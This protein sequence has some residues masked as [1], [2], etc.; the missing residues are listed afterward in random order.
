MRASAATALACAL[1]GAGCGP[2]VDCEALC[3]RLLACRVTLDAPDDPEGAKIEAGERTEDESCALGCA[4]SGV[5]TVERARCVD[6]VEIR[7]PGVCQD[8]ML[9]CLEQR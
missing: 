9:V 7:D 4:G 2:T 8:E 5:V 6:A 3:D 1:L